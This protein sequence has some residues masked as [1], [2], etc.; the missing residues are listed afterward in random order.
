M[1][2]IAN[3]EQCFSGPFQ[4]LCIGEVDCAPRLEQAK[5]VAKKKATPKLGKSKGKGLKNAGVSASGLD[6]AKPGKLSPSE[7]QKQKAKEW[8][9]LLN[10]SAG[11]QGEPLGKSI[12]GADQTLIAMKK[13]NNDETPEYLLLSAHVQLAKLTKDLGCVTSEWNTKTS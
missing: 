6:S 2:F 11:L 4:V 3:G 12:W 7:K 8:L 5:A 1:G 9:P 10:I 13:G